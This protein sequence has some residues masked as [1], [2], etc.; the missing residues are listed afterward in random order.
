MVNKFNADQIAAAS[1]VAR[2]VAQGL[3]KVISDG[4]G[5]MTRLRDERI[6]KWVMTN[7]PGAPAY[8]KDLRDYLSNPDD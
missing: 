3:G 2:T 7:I 1:K 6:I 4:I 5:E 8:E